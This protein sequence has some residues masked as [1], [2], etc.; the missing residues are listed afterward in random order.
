MRRVL[1][2][3]ATGFIGSQVIPALLARGFE[4]H[5]VARE[6]PDGADNR[7]VWHGA[8]LLDDAAAAGAVRAAGASH[9][10][11]L[12]WVTGHGKYWESP[13]NLDWVAATLRLVHVFRSAGGRRVVVAGTCAEYDWGGPCCDEQTPL[14]PATLYGTAKDATRRVLE[15]YAAREELSLAWG[16]IFFVY[17]PREQPERVVASVAR[18]VVAGE[19]VACTSGRQ[20]RDYLYV[21]D[22]ASAFAA[23]VDS[24]L[25]GRLDIGSG[26]GLPLRDVLLELERLAGREALVRLGEASER[27]SEPA[28]IVAD[29]RR[30][31]DELGWQPECGL[32]A[33]LER[34]LAWWQ[35]HSLARQ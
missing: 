23:L 20:I 11:H 25:E 22:V 19:Q 24:S 34:T 9:L 17:G 21:E 27:G 35:M 28:S 18:A 4:V 13:A 30:L 31:R 8:D 29:T 12:A 15:R 26:E 3:G 10:L 33:G 14:R 5:A 32:Q 1:V 7:V 6:T 16:R 2:T